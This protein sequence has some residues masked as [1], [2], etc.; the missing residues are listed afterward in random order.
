MSKKGHRENFI[1]L[2]EKGGKMHYFRDAVLKSMR[3]GE[4]K[5][6][7]EGEIKGIRKGKI[8]GMRSGMVESTLNLARAK[9]GRLDEAEEQRLRKREIDELKRI[10]QKIL[11]ASAFEELFG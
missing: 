1:H 3:E 9:F 2:I 11:S 6:M 7:R 10:Q 8:E 5:G 4:I